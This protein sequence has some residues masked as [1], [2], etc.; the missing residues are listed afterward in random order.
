M[1]HPNVVEKNG[2]YILLWSYGEGNS[3]GSDGYKVVY[4]TASSPLGTYTVGSGNPLMYTGENPGVRAPGATSIVKDGNGINWVVYRQ[5]KDNTTTR[6]LVICI[7]RAY[8][9]M[10]GTVNINATR[11]TT[12]TAPVP[13]P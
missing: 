2:H 12:E 10:D 5:K 9:H 6:D 4:A 3:V 8:L 13:L 7:D 11:G 1:E